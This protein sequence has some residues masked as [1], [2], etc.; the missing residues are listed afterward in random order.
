MSGGASFETP[1][2]RAPQDEGL[3]LCH[4][5]N[6]L[7]LRS[8][9]GER[10]GASRRTRGRPCSGGSRQGTAIL[11][12][13]RCADGSYYVGI[14]RY[15]VEKRIAEHQEGTCAGYTSRRRP[16]ELVFHETLDPVEDA[17]AAERQIKGWRRAKKDALIRSDFEQNPLRFERLAAAPHPPCFAWS[18][19]LALRGRKNLKAP[20]PATRG[21]WRAQRAGGGCGLAIRRDRITL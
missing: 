2:V 4:P 20:S 5:T 1:A 12:M 8:A 10:R 16:V 17:I 3:S 13:L 15:S 11:T 9:A 6:Y 18:P 19:S 14:T 21:R 7:I